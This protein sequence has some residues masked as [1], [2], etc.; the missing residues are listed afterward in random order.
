ML[1][2]VV[3]VSGRPDAAAQ[4]A[5]VMGLAPADFNRRVVGT[6]PRVLAL[7]L[8]EDEAR[9]AAAKLEGLG[10]QV[11]ICDPA[12]APGDRERV[13]ARRMQFAGP[14]LQIADSSEK[15]HVCPL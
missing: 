5:K 14:D 6:L 8:A 10:F 7:G 13:V 12:L 15:A 2:A 1:I 11:V 4:G 9:E 3:R